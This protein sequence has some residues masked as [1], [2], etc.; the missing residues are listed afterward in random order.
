V[1]HAQPVPVGSRPRLS[2]RTRDLFLICGALAALVALA[3]AYLVRLA[4]NMSELP[5][6]DPASAAGLHPWAALD[7]LLMFAMWAVM[8]VGMMVPTAMR[9]VMIYAGIAE[10]AGSQGKVVASTYWFVGGYVIVWTAFGLVA[11]LVQAG[12]D[13][14]GLL[15]P[16]MVSLSAG[17]GAGLLIGAGVYQLTPWKDTCLQHCQS[18]AM[19]I[20]R[21][22]GPSTASAI[23]L[24]VR[25][26]AYCLGCCWV[27]MGLLFLGGVMNLLWIAAIT[28]FVLLEKLLPPVLRVARVGGVLMIAWGVA[29]LLLG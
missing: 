26:G 2:I 18:P 8:M 19:Y 20:A 1:S 24:G 5:M 25:H 28:G 11:T 10:R 6:S 17:L 12:L 23:S 22:F 15:S 4:S 14:L 7:F 3:W 27:L 29:Y 9:A 13:R 16:M 21:H